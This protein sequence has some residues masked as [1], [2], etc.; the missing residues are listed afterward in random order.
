[1][2]GVSVTIKRFVKLLLSMSC[3]LTDGDVSTQ[4]LHCN[5]IMM[6]VVAALPDNVYRHLLGWYE[7]GEVYCRNKHMVDKFIWLMSVEILQFNKLL[8]CS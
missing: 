5:Y 7:C 3:M 4:H 6:A 2:I 8:Y 1:M